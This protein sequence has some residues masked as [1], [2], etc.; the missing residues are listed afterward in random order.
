[1]AMKLPIFTIPSHSKNTK[2]GIFWYEKY[3]V[4]QP[5]FEGSSKKRS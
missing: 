1:M 5:W 3:T 4:R 2:I